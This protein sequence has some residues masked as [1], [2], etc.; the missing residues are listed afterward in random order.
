MCV[1]VCVCVRARVCV[2]V[3]ACVCEGG[4][5]AWGRILQGYNSLIKIKTRFAFY[6]VRLELSS[7]LVG[8]RLQVFVQALLLPQNSE[9][10]NRSITQFQ[11]RVLCFYP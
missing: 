4:G 7:L 8:E 9:P 11:H 1:C 10:A 6:E 3:C 5:G 2:C